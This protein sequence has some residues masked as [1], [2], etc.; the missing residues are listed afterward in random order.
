VP[1]FTVETFRV[2][3]KT[4]LFDSTTLPVPV[5]LEVPVPPLATGTMPVSEMLG[6]TPPLELNGEVAPT[7]STPV[8]EMVVALGAELTA[9]PVPA[10]TLLTSV[11]GTQTVPL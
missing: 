9:M 2:P 3:V 7:L 5:A 1:A 6:V 4:G 11:L 8:L 10:V